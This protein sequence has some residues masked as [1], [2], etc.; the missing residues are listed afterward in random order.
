MVLLRLAAK[1]GDDVGGDGTFGHQRLDSPHALHIIVAGIAAVHPFQHGIAA[2]LYGQMDILADVVV[3][4]NG[5][6][7]FV[8][9]I[10]GMGGGETHP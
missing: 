3:T 10:L 1:T 5:L 9:D 6:Y 7:Q 4:G 8:G 2:R